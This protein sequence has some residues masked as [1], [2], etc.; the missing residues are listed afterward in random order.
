[1]TLSRH[2]YKSLFF[3]LDD[4]LWDTTH[5]NKLCL[6]EIYSDYHFGRHYASFEEFYDTYFPYN[7]ELWAKYRNNEIDRRTLIAE[8]LLYVLRPMGID[9]EAFALKLNNDFLQRTATKTKLLDGAIDLMEY[10]SPKYRLFV[11]SNGFREIQ[12]RK[13]LNSGL[14]PYFERILLSE[15]IS[16]Q[17]PHRKI[18]EFALKSTNS[19]RSESLMIGDAYEVDVVG[20][21]NTRIDQLWFNPSCIEPK[22]PPPT[23][24]VRS[25][26][27]IKDIL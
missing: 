20:A 10:L 12:S 6:Q 23:F 21:Q 4:T 19:R 9:D 7:Q 15:D 1:M 25:L 16:I 3:D 26:S 11:L 24:T 5:N 14:A 18:F 17:K 2:K 8:R 27:E 13:M 22:G